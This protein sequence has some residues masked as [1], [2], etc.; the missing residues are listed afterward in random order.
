MRVLRPIPVFV[1]WQIQV[2]PSK[3]VLPVM[4]AVYP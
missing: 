3:I 4:D 2:E 1:S